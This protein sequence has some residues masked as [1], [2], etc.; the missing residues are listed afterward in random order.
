MHELN[1]DER[2]ANAILRRARLHVVAGTGL[3]G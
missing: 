2:D 3:D 1:A